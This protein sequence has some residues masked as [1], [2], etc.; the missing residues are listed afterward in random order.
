LL[1]V[2]V[3]AQQPSSPVKQMTSDVVEA[4]SRPLNAKTYN[5]MVR[6]DIKIHSM[7]DGIGNELNFDCF[8]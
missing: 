4:H 3:S 6:A 7:S 2:L 1:K 5:Y 8:C